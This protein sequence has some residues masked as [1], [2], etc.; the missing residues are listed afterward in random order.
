[1]QKSNFLFCMEIYEYKN[2][3]VTKSVTPLLYA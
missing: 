3:G 2:N 1:M